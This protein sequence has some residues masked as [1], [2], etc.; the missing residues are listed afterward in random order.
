MDE[1]SIFVLL[2]VIIFCALAYQKYKE[3]YYAF[4]SETLD[5]DDFF[6]KDVKHLNLSMKRKIWIHLP[7]E[8]NARKWEHFGSRSSYDLNID[9]MVLCIKSIIDYCGQYYDVILFDD[10]N[11][12]TLLPDQNVEYE[13][14][15]GDL[16]DKY[17]QKSL[18]QILYDYG[19]VMM[20]PSMYLR[21]TIYNI[22]KTNTF[23]VSEIPN[24]GGHSTTQNMVYSTKL[25]GS[26]KQNPIL[27]EYIRSYSDMCL[28][29]LTNESNY[30]SDQLLKKMNIPLLNGLLIGT[31]DKNNH[32]IRLEDL[33]ESHAIE[34]HPSH[35]GIYI[36]HDELMRRTKYNWYAYLT[37]EQV[38]E[39]NVFI[40]KYMLEH[41]KSKI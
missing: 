30:F 22:D 38:L 8:R 29:D 40:S 10:S 39:T 37:S 5:V 7:I 19:G 41:G 17:R 18:L 2:I 35:I 23:Y 9:Y 11:I 24:Q 14:L 28:K 32:P 13:K 25:T 33:M 21:N 27:G 26:N 3:R 20:P 15:S 31:R 1:M 34:L 12:S 4:K 6:F 16:L 36:P